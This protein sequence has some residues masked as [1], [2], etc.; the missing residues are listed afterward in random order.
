MSVEEILE[1]PDVAERVELYLEQADRRS[2]RS[3][4]RHRAR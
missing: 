4:L 1:L 2:S 3:A